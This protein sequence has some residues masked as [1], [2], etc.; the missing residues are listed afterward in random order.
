MNA[1]SPSGRSLVR[2]AEPFRTNQRLRLEL[3]EAVA[4]VLD[5]GVYILGSEV[6]SFEREFSGYLGAG[7][8]VG[9]SSGT[10]AIELALRALSV[11]PGDAVFTVSH[12]SVATVAAIELVGAT[13][14][15]LDVDCETFTLDPADLEAT[16]ES[17][18]SGI[19]GRPLRPKVVIPVHLYGHP[20]SMSEIV[21]I[22]RANSLQ[23]VEDASQ[24][25]GARIGNTPVGLT[26]DLGAFSLYPTKN[27]GALGDAGVV[28]GRDPDLVGRIRRLRQYGWD[29]P[30][31][32]VMAGTNHRLD[33][34]QAAILR[35]KL[36]YLESWNRRRREI[37]SR[38]HSELP[39][40]RLQLPRI[41]EGCTHVFHQF[42]V[43][44]P[45]RDLLRSHLLARGVEA[46]IHYPKPVHL[47]SAYAGRLA[48]GVSGLRCTEDISGQ[49][50]SLPVHHDLTDDEVTRVIET[51]KS[52]WN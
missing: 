29:R 31:N 18:A 32:S 49:I 5:S 46:G 4:R 28:V 9:V 11:G 3:L 45:E 13:P 34:I 12:T 14:V 16:I 30:Q 33:E 41:Q 48:V 35:S 50:L 40:A 25:H 8:A 43:R 51:I 27:L 23:I 19:F 36:P 10:A 38:Y 7:F 15:L 1:V 22:C 6:E 52:F 24:A 39:S 20:A 37:A 21:R 42:V 26:G 44:S 47:Q 17:V 2:T